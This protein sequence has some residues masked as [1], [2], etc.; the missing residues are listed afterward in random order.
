MGGLSSNLLTR[1]IF[2]LT[3]GFENW[4]KCNNLSYILNMDFPPPILWCRHIGGH[5]QEELTKVKNKDWKVENSCY[6]LVTC[7]KMLFKYGNFKKNPLKFGDFDTFLPKIL[8][9]LITLDF[10]LPLYKT[11]PHKKKKKKGEKGWKCLHLTNYSITWIFHLMG[12]PF[13]Q[14]FNLN[15]SKLK[16]KLKYAIGIWN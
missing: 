11:F 12:S 6:V 4:T 7:W 2:E 1:H 5:P 10:L 14:I 13:L 3:I 8:L 15:L 9:C 16:G